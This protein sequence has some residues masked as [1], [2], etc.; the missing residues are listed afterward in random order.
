MFHLEW[1]VGDHI[2]YET[3]KYM[4]DYVLKI[5]HDIVI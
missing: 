4:K 3:T 5:S 1:E 2:L